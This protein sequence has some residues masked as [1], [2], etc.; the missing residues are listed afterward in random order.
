MALDFDGFRDWMYDEEEL[1]ENTVNT[2]IHALKLY[3]Q[4]YDDV[5]KQSIIAYKND[6]LK[7]YKPSTVNLRLAAI[8]AYCKYIRSPVK[9]KSVKLPRR[10]HIENV[11]TQEHINRLLESLAAEKNR[12]WIVNILMLSKTGMRI[13]EAV[14]VT[15][16][17][18]LA[19]SV[20]MHTKGHMR[21]IRFP[22]KL[23]REIS[24]DL[25]QLGPYDKIMRT[26]RGQPIGISGLQGGLK[27]LARRYGIPAEVMHA[28]SFRHFFAIEFLKR[29][30]DIVM[31]ADI[32]GHSS[33]NMTRIYLQQ[34]LEQQQDALD[35]TVDW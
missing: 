20:T 7:K 9:I 30:N 5:S 16:R 4:K 13:S 33:V 10:T 12:C 14:R 2:Y 8:F 27:R 26:K 29:K 18:V 3:S 25:E 22:K 24:D 34:S 19:G 31:L 17:D 15:K 23:V 21:T 11:I 6:M 28:H 32:L 1:A 35:K